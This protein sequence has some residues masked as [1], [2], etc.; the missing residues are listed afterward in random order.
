MIE[1]KAP[2]VDVNVGDKT[3]VAALP[4]GADTL[5]STAN[6]LT[7]TITTVPGGDSLSTT[8]TPT[9]Y[10]GQDGI[11]EVAIT[12]NGTVFKNLQEYLGNLGHMV[13]LG[14][15]LEFI[16]AHPMLGDVNNQTGY[17]PFMVTFP[18]AGQYKL[19]LQTQANNAVST[20]GF[21]VTVQQMPK[22][23][24]NDKPMQGM[25]HMSH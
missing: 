20:F 13:I 5:T 25:D 22:S 3:K 12:K 10:A 8:T 14:P 16:H 19:Y 15:N 1:T 23:T 2:Y 7:A 11:L 9:F 18:T 24:G 4:L 6:G 21:N 17:I